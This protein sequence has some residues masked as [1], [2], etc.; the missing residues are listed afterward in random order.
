MSAENF[1][2]DSLV[3]FI[4]TK[5]KLL[6]LTLLLHSCY[7]IHLSCFKFRLGC[8]IQTVSSCVLAGDLTQWGLANWSFLGVN[9]IEIISNNV[10]L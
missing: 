2:G 5:G 9:T 1:Q 8:L 7:F 4:V 10:Q 6:T 3:L